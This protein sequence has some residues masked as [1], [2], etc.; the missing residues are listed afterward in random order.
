[1]S[2][3]QTPQVLRLP[4]VISMIGISKG[5]IYAYIKRG[6]FPAPIKL[7]PKASGW[8]ASDVQAWIAER[9]AAR[10]VQ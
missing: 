8:L 1:M 6:A 2:N 5:S 3:T 7:G 10:G 4:A 9:T